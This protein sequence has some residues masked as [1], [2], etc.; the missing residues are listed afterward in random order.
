MLVGI[1]SIILNVVF[2][3]V[4]HIDMYTE[5]AYMPDG[6]I[7]HWIYSPVRK[8]DHAGEVDIVNLQYVLV[9]ISI[10]S[11]L[12]VIFGVKHK[13]VKIV[14]IVSIIASAVVFTVIM[15]M[16]SRIHLKY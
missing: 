10:I 12:L 6:E 15:I 5:S 11:S 9:A 4:L 14:Q 3:V 1:I 13:I 2:C 16:S 8:L 7:R